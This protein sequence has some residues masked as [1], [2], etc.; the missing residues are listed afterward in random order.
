M[1]KQFLHPGV[2]DKPRSCCVKLRCKSMYYRHDE[3]PGKLHD[4][5][6]MGYWCEDT[7][8]AAGPDSVVAN[9]KKCQPGRGCFEPG[10]EVSV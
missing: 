8:E 5:D 2:D 3:R 7:C 10:P 6:A 4:E 1:D 9:H